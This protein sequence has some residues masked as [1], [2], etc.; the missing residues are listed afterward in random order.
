M[1]TS[2]SKGTSNLLNL[3]W[4]WFRSPHSASQTRVNALMSDSL[5]E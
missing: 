3:A 1:R 4:L 2:E 5:Q